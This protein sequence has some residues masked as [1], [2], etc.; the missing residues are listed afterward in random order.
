MLVCDAIFLYIGNYLEFRILTIMS[1]SDPQ[2]L[3]MILILPSLFGLTL[4][5][6][7]IS[8]LIHDDNGGWLSV[9]FGVMFIIV[10]FFAYFFFS[11]MLKPHGV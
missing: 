11:S 7:G 6:E 1:P 10:V 5:G 4:I 2:F 8:K 9:V 3:Y